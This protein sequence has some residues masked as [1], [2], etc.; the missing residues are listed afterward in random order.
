[1]S[2]LLWVFA[3]LGLTNS[4]AYTGTLKQ[5][6]GYHYI[7]GKGCGITTP[8]KYLEE[9]PDNIQG[10]SC[11]I[12]R[13]KKITK[14]KTQ[15]E[16]ED[17]LPPTPI[18]GKNMSFLFLLCK[19]ETD[20]VKRIECEF[21]NMDIRHDMYESSTEPDKFECAKK[22]RAHPQ[23]EYF[24]YLPSGYC[25]LRWILTSEPYQPD[26][27]YADMVGSY[28]SCRFPKNHYKGKI[29]LRVSEIF[30]SRILTLTL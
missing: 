22:C 15:K 18:E 20:F 1:M 27:T 5:R 11:T 8:I 9:V 7:T 30:L 17:L 14:A 25:S 24:N 23:C 12:I 19:Q 2:M 21:K 16:I 13:P 3:V 26:Q 28:K 6:N 4:E 29:D 10:M